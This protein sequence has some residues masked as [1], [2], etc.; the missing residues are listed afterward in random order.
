LVTLAAGLRV[1]MV[2]EGVETQEQLD[3]LTRLG[4]RE[5]QG[6]LLAVPMTITQLVEFLADTSTGSPRDWR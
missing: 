6:Y 2:A 4:C 3:S 5:V 1:G